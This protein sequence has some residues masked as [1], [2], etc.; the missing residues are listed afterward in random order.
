MVTTNQRHMIRTQVRLVDP[1]GSSRVAAT[2]DV[3]PARR[4]RRH[5]QSRTRPVRRIVRV[6][7]ASRAAAPRWLTYLQVVLGVGASLVTIARTLI[8][9]FHRS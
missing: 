1:A 2:R 4:R 3:S 9:L 8:E 7:I 5:A 6:A